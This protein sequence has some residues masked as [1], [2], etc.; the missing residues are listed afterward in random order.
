MIG[1]RFYRSI[2]PQ[3][4]TSVALPWFLLRDVADSHEGSGYLTVITAISALY[5]TILNRLNKLSIKTIIVATP[6]M[7]IIIVG[8]QRS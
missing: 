3:A 2:V 4:V 5:N 8:L 6:Y 1:V 7:T